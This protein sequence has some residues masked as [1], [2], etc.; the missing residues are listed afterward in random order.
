MTATLEPVAAGE[1]YFLG[2]E[3]RHVRRFHRLVTGALDLWCATTGGR[4]E[5]TG[6]G[7]V[8]V[9]RRRDGVAELKVATGGPEAA[10]VLMDVLRN[11][12]DTMAPD[13]FRDA[14]GL[15]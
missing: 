8:V 12:L 13:E 4:F 6:E 3:P 2:L 9:R 14:W 7:F 1:V 15:D 5:L 11:Q 10:A